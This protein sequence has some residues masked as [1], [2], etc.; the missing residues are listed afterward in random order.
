MPN[1]HIIIATGGTGGHIFPARA[2]AHALHRSGFKITIFADDKYLKYS[3]RKDPYNYKIISSS[4]LCNGFLNKIR[5]LFKIALATCKSLLLIL[6]YRPQVIV[7]FG[8]YATFPVLI[9]ATILKRKIILHEQNA[10]LGRVNRLF[11][12]YASKIALSYPQTGGI[13]PEYQNNTIF[14]GN[15][16][17]KKIKAL[18]KNEYQLPTSNKPEKNKKV[19][20]LGYNLLLASQFNRQ[21][22]NDEHIG[23]LFNILVIGGSGGAKIFSDILPKAFFNLKESLKEQINIIQQCR[24]EY[25]EYTFNQYQNFNLNILIDRFFS[26]IDKKIKNAHLII[27]R[28]GSSSIAEFTAAKKPMILVPFAKAAD[29]HQEKNAAFI[30]KSGAAV[31]FKEQN[32]TINK[33]TKCLEKLIE[34][35]GILKKMSQNSFSCANLNADL[36]MVKLVKSFLI[37]TLAHQNKTNTNSF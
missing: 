20:N 35:P 25:I 19:N 10:H 21:Y 2:T 6:Y 4:Q 8:G 30:E 13:N 14:T 16:I 12:K 22:Q 27:A 36:N 15:P 7:A 3:E 18:S 17:R 5:A 29:N 26:D 33:V 28:A 37:P 32:F 11:I 34:H 9:A 23:N 24:P 1:K 31:V